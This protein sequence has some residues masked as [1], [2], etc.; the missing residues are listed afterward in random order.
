VSIALWAMPAHTGMHSCMGASFYACAVTNSWVSYPDLGLGTRLQIFASAYAARM[1]LL[2]S[3]FRKVKRVT[4]THRT[5]CGMLV[6]TGRC[7]I[8][9]SPPASQNKQRNTGRI[10]QGQC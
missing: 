6:W 10:G 7:I 8:C 2:F 5:K 9:I 3:S 4:D 1:G